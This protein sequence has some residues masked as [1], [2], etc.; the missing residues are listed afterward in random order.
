MKVRFYRDEYPNKFEI[1]KLNEE[2][3]ASMQEVA[4]EYSEEYSHYVVSVDYDEQGIYF[5]LDGPWEC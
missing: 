5:Y 4:D 2:S 1:V 3:I